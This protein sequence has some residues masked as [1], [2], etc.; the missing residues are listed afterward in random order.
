MI[1][2]SQTRSPS[3]AARYPAE[4]SRSPI[5]LVA[6]FATRQ[7]RE[8]TGTSCRGS[9]SSA[10]S[11]PAWPPPL[12]RSLCPCLD[13]RASVGGPPRF[14]RFPESRRDLRELREFPR[15][16]RASINRAHRER[17]GSSYTP[18]S[19]LE[20][21]RSRALEGKAIS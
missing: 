17:T 12:C 11:C 15:K 9:F 6:L 5:S 8:R 10:S 21:G 1:A 4:K 14:V 20:G 7:P 18:L 19:G 3:I 2:R 16:M 13:P